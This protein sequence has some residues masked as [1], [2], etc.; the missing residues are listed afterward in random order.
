[1]SVE[2]LA[3]LDFLVA[4]SSSIC[5]LQSEVLPAE[6]ARGIFSPNAASLAAPQST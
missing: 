3:G 1:M 4:V 5:R 6:F 2:K